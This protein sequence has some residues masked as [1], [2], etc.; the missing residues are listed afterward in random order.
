VA[1]PVAGSRELRD[2]PV[3]SAA[4][5][6]DR[7]R[8]SHMGE[9]RPGRPR[10]GHTCVSRRTNTDR[11]ARFCSRGS[12]IFIHRLQPS[13]NSY[14][15]SSAMACAGRSPSLSHGFSIVDGLC[16]FTPPMPWAAWTDGA[17]FGS[18]PILPLSS[19]SFGVPKGY[20]SSSLGCSRRASP[21]RWCGS[22]ADRLVSRGRSIW[23]RPR[24]SLSGQ[25]SGCHA[26][27]PYARVLCMAGLRPLVSGSSLAGG[28]LACFSIIDAGYARP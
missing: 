8:V 22:V 17:V 5:A 13:W 18:F 15:L 21:R 24:R 12:R 9:L 2:L 28:R 14:A 4:L 10:R 6:C 7:P 26:Q 25:A 23:N 19:L 27:A 20:P 1:Q 3:T 11:L 16:S